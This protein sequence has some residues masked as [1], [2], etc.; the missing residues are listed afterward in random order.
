[1]PLALGRALV[2]A[3]GAHSVAGMQSSRER[4]SYQAVIPASA[5]RRGT[6]P[7]PRARRRKAWVDLADALERYLRAHPA[8]VTP[9][10]A[11][12]VVRLAAG[13][14]S[15]PAPDGSQWFVRTIVDYD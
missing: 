5:V 11:A 10:W 15:T 4:R 12:W 2:S 9:A 8:A 14:T 7:P 3:N 1:M 6:P 13:D